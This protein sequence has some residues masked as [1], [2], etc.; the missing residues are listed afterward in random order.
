MSFVQFIFKAN[1]F[2]FLQVLLVS[3]TTAVQKLMCAHQ[4]S[5]F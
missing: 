1:I 4:G 5:Q 3:K 2:H